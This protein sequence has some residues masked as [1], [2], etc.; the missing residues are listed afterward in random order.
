MGAIF[1]IVYYLPVLL[2]AQNSADSVIQTDL[3][4][5]IDFY[6]W[7]VSE[8]SSGSLVVLGLNL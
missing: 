8:L 6:N 2:H 5:F 4:L 3:Y 1:C 7:E